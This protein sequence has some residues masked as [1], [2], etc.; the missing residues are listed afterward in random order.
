MV[1]QR[2]P[3]RPVGVDGQPVVHTR[4]RTHAEHLAVGEGPGRGVVA[5]LV[6]R[7]RVRLRE[8]EPLPIG[9]EPHPV[10]Q[11]DALYH[12]GDRPIGVEPVE[13]PRRGVVVVHRPAE[14]PS[15]RVSDDVVEP[16]PCLPGDAVDH[17]GEVPVVPASHPSLLHE[18]QERAVRL[19]GERADDLPLVEAL[20]PVGP[21]VV[22]I[23]PSFDVVD[24][25]QPSVVGVPQ[26]SLAD[27]TP[28]FC[29]CLENEHFF[30]TR[31]NQCIPS[32]RPPFASA[33]PGRSSGLG[34]EELGGLTGIDGHRRT[35]RHCEMNR[36]FW[37]EM[38]TIVIRLGYR[39]LVEMADDAERN[40]DT[41]LRCRPVGGGGSR[42]VE[43][44]NVPRSTP[45]G[46]EA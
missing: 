35:G 8:V 4:S 16:H 17:G 13:P 43:T 28:L 6:D 5:E 26:R 12:F 1:P 2:R 3:D 10:G 24:P 11:L 46:R 34:V 21:G 9:G 33:A 25:V 29:D 32:G 39:I 40:A 22:P 44:S 45:G 38:V 23:H 30:D 15:A 27:G 37:L 19:D 14:D 20:G 36:R 31:R 18:Q 42:A 7:V 41:A